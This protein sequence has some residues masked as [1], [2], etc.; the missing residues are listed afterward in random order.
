VPLLIASGAAGG[1]LWGAGTAALHIRGRVSEIFAG[2]GANFLAQGFALY[3]V[4]GPWKRPG[5][6]SMS[7][8]EPLDPALWLSTFGSTD[9]SPAALLLGILAVVLVALVMRKTT[10]GLRLRAVGLNRR[11]AEV[12]G[13]RT[14]QHLFAS[15][16]LCGALAGV[17]GA[18]QVVGVFHRLIPNISSNLGFL[19]LLVVMLARFDAR[20]VLPVALFFSALNVGSLQLP[21]TLELESSLAGVIQGTLVLFV[22]LAPR[23]KGGAE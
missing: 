7:G 4:F 21:M 15:F 23:G 16:A 1:A 22:L 18:L 19:A 2:L 20:L 8:T 9:A 14:A 3:L 11:A 12:L 13:V 17:G 6:A 10:F 5:I